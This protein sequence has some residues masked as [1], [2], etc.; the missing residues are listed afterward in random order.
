MLALCLT[1]WNRPDCLRGLLRSLRR[2]R[3]LQDWQLFVQLEPSERQEE[4]ISSLQAAHLPC[5]VELVCNAV[6]QGVRANPLL[7]LE[8]AWGMGAKAFLLLE[9][10]LEL[11]ADALEFVLNSLQLTDWDIR[12]A[13]GNLHFSTCF[14]HAHLQG[15]NRADAQSALVAME[16]YFLS[17]LG[18]FFSRDQYERWIR[19]HWWDRGL[20]LR[21][22]HGDRVSGW[23]C[24]LNQA[25]LLGS[26]P[27]L[28]SLLPRVRHCGIEGV[29]SDA[30][31]HQMSY[32]HAGLH[33]GDV[34]LPELQVYSLDRLNAGCPEAE[35]WAVLLRL[36]SQLWELQR[37]SLLRQLELARCGE[38]LKDLLGLAAA[39]GS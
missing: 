4:L 23:D 3:G 8:R 32:A 26:R 20:G 16:T 37:S 11:S 13:C 14:N 34:P 5:R 39:D 15:W 10:D 33:A 36:A 30:V 31:L 1:V 35:S 29:H 19:I 25:L 7:C 21:S 27:C 22:F 17:S 24:A 12:Y 6:R 9:D 2:V 28:Q 18:L 38:Q